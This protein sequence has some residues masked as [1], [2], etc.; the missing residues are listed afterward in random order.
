PRE[1]KP[2]EEVK[3]NIRQYLL[4]EQKRVKTEHLLAE[5]RKKGTITISEALGAPTPTPSDTGSEGE[6][7]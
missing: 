5:L 6:K 7:E 1:T 3:E 4:E 2:F